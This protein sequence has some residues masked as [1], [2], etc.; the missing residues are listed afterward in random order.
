MKP[1]YYGTDEET[2]LELGGRYY[3]IQSPDL[4]DR[5]YEQL[6]D[7]PEGFEPIDPRL[8]SDLEIPNDLQA[9]E[10]MAPVR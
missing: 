5:E 8:C 1:H 9:E 4:G 2:I 7:L 6:R 10:T 3:L